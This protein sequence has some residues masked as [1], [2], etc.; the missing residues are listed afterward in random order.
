MRVGTGALKAGIVL[1]KSEVGRADW[2]HCMLD[3]VNQ[4]K[5]FEVNLQYKEIM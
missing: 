2:H 1:V 5:G 3:V 4:E